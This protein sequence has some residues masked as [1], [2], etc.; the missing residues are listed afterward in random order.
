VEHDEA[1]EPVS[2]RFR[3]RETTAE[4]LEDVLSV[5][6][7]NPEFLSLRDNAS[8]I[9]GGYDQ[10]SVK[11]YW[12]L[13]TLDPQR[14]LMLVAEAATGMAVGLVDFIDQSPVDRLP[15]IGLVMV[16]GRWQRRGAGTAALKGVTDHLA[17]KGHRAVRMAVFEAN[18]AGLGFARRC[19]FEPYGSAEAS[20]METSRRVVL[21]E[22]GLAPVP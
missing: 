10:A 4:D 9:A 16:H 7:S 19:G 3:L 5:F 17:S 22:L 6:R 14:H 15:W 18:E 1:L 11:Q 21:L 2:D 20:T 8:A 12:E 13:A